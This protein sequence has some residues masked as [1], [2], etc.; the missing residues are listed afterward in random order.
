[1]VDNEHKFLLLVFAPDHDASREIRAVFLGVESSK[2]NELKGYAVSVGGN[3]TI[4][5]PHIIGVFL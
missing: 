5:H 1:L 2:E 3:R 4:F